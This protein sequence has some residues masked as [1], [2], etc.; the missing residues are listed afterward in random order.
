M[1]LQVYV[2][3][4]YPSAEASTAN[5]THGWGKPHVEVLSCTP[6]GEAATPGMETG[7]DHKCG[8]QIPGFDPGSAEGK[9]PGPGPVLDH[10]TS[11][12]SS[13]C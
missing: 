8:A 1:A 2:F 7:L 11:F 10:T 12:R 3:A 13:N 9:Q 4:P 5:L 6:A